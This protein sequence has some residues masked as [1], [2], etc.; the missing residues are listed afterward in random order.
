[1]VCVVEVDAAA[2]GA[3]LDGEL[4]G[5]AGDALEGAADREALVGS[6]EVGPLEPGDFATAH[7]GVGGEVQRRVEP[8]WPAAARNAGQFFGGPGSGDLAGS[9]AGGGRWWLGD[10]GVDELA[11]QGEVERGADDHVDLV[12]GLGGETG[13]VTAAGG[14][15][16]VVE[17][18]EVVGP[19]STERDV[20][21]RRVDVV[22]DDPRVAV[23]RWWLGRDGA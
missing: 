21:D 15:E 11:A 18:V 20:A 6:V 8:L 2:A 13:A 19:E 23:R 4:D 22:V 10:V 12:H 3:G 14:G 1:M 17:V 5:L 16:L 7:P 9:G